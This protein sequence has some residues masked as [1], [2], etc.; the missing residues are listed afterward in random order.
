LTLTGVGGA[1]K[2]RLALQVAADLKDAFSDGVYFVALAAIRDPSLVV[3]TVAQTLGIRESGSQP[4]SDSLVGWLRDKRLLLVLDNFEQILDAASFVADLLARCVSLK[5]MVT[6]RAPLRL[7]GEQQYRVPPL[8][9]PPVR[10]EPHLLLEGELRTA[11]Y[12]AVRLFSQRARQ[13]RPDFMLTEANRQTMAEI[14]HRL[15]GLPLALELAAARVHLLPPSAMLQRLSP[16]LAL[17]TGGPR[18][19]PGRCRPAW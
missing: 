7:Q 14:C 13:V 19:R 9:L 11:D 15:D 1:G 2:T 18:D 12:P 10:E 16:R 17:L 8:A 4:L 6:S 3:S 5:V